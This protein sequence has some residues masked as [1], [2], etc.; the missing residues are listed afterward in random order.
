MNVYN[1]AGRRVC[2]VPAGIETKDAGA[3]LAEVKTAIDGYGKAAA[4]GFKKTGEQLAEI[5]A[6]VGQ[7]EQKLSRRGGGPV[8][9]DTPKTWGGTVTE[10]DEFK[11]FVAGGARGL[12]R[13][14]VKTVTTAMDSGGA[15]IPPDRQAEVIT[16]PRRRLTVRS[17]LAPGTTT[18]NSIQFM[19]ETLYT[20]AAGVVAEAALKPQSDIRYE[21]QDSGVK[22]IAHWIPVSRQAMDD[23]PQ[24]Q[25][26]IDNAL[27]FGLAY[28]EELQLLLGSGTGENILGLVPASTD[29]ADAANV[30]GDNK[31]DTILRAITQAE[32]ASQL[33]ATG[34]IVN[35]TDWAGMIGLKGADGHYLSNGP[36]GTTAPTLWGRPVVETPAM[37]AGEF[38]VGNFN[39][40][41]QIF[42]RM[43]AEVLI[44]Q[45]HADF[46]VKNLLAVRAEERLALVVKRPQ[47]LVHGAY[48]V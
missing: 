28:V 9:G 34:I 26:V 36:F 31:A 5:D 6:R 11:S 35:S 44:S 43:T 37:P 46:F 22:T 48:P 24:L 14:E 4:D 20:N 29:Y 19:R 8:G 17:L 12:M 27:R 1:M 15:L 21:L 42:D 13:V 3:G 30:A 45:D 23:A 18:S 25:S 7:V 32:T 47:A 40:A 39:Q 16:L 41:A 33:P 38:L 2:A 10:S